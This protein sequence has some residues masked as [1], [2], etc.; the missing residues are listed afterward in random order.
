MEFRTGS[1]TARPRRIDR[2]YSK[3]IW[4]GSEHLRRRGG[5]E[6]ERL[7]NNIEAL[8]YYSQTWMNLRCAIFARHPE[9]REAVGP[10][11]R[12]SGRFDS[13]PQLMFPLDEGEYMHLRGSGSK[14]ELLALLESPSRETAKDLAAGRKAESDL[15]RR[16]KIVMEKLNELREKLEQRNPK[17][18]QRCREAKSQKNKAKTKV[19]KKELSASHEDLYH[20]KKILSCL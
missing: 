1:S 5:Q 9:L 8:W 12:M 6:R 13:D 14:A 15:V 10:G 19:L 20:I 16:E 7:V 2:I 18:E 3:A 11:G 17:T 4:E